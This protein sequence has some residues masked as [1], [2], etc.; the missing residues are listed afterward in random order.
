MGWTQQHEQSPLSEKSRSEGSQ[1]LHEFESKSR[2]L[3]TDFENRQEEME[4]HVHD[5]RY[6]KGAVQIDEIRSERCTM[7]NENQEVTLKKK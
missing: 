2:D 1:L 4:K 6:L 3:E 7:E 5:I